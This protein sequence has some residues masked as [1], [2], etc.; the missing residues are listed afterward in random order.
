MRKQD[1]EALLI[2]WM[3]GHLLEL[4]NN[5]LTIGSTTFTLY[6]VDYYCNLAW[7]PKEYQ[8]AVLQFEAC[9][10]LQRTTSIHAR[11]VAFR[12][13]YTQ[14]IRQY[15][16][17]AGPELLVTSIGRQYYATQLLQFACLSKLCAQLETFQAGQ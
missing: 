9:G 6:A 5:A 10:I 1:T 7:H 13:L 16:H 2:E 17:I 12:L 11:I 4:S 14:L 8:W 15:K 3:L